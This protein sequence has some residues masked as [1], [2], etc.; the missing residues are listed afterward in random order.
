VV[1]WCNSYTIVHCSL[2]IIEWFKYKL[3]KDFLNCTGVDTDS[4]PLSVST[5]STW[6]NHPSLGSNGLHCIEFPGEREKRLLD[7]HLG[8]LLVLLETLRC[9]VCGSLS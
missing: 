8:E 5:I 3:K 7:L 4:P 9:L 6:I 1:Y 2:D